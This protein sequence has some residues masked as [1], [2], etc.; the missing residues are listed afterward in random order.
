[1][2]LFDRILSSVARRQP[3]ARSPRDLASPTTEQIAVMSVANII[4]LLLDLSKTENYIP[5]ADIL[6]RLLNI[7]YFDH[8][9]STGEREQAAQVADRLEKSLVGWL[10]E[11]DGE[12]L[13]KATATHKRG[14]KFFGIGSIYWLAEENR[15]PSSEWI[16]FAMRLEHGPKLSAFLEYLGEEGRT[17]DM[18]RLFIHQ[19]IVT[20]RKGMSI[21]AV[22]ILHGLVTSMD[23]ATI[24]LFS[25]NEME[26]FIQAP[27][28]YDRAREILASLSLLPP[29][30][31]AKP[32]VELPRG[33]LQNLGLHIVGGFYKEWAAEDEQKTL[34]LSL[35]DSYRGAVGCVAMA[36]AMNLTIRIVLQTLGPEAAKVV[37]SGVE[38]AFVG[39]SMD[40]EY[41]IG[42]IA[43]T[44]TFLFEKIQQ[45][46]GEGALI[47]SDTLIVFK[48]LEAA[49]EFPNSEQD[50]QAAEELQAKLSFFFGQLRTEVISNIR[51]KLLY[52]GHPTSEPQSQE[53]LAR[54]ASMGAWAPEAERSTLLEDWVGYD[55]LTLADLALISRSVTRHK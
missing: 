36:V 55:I 1:M 50:G 30:G 44:E 46:G 26:A 17:P 45:G 27:D 37:A 31:N 48:M 22:A 41:F 4:K 51:F 54:Y 14:I 8:H 9:V 28:N 19:L 43:E 18:R 47:S 13:I 7:A 5:A 38:E 39:Q 29:H 32:F 42:A 34:L 11:R 35:P 53:T 21:N 15:I 52:L 49:D 10:G 23:S 3:P 33:A 40:W 12:V 16:Q 20:R 24:A 25:P 2:G 6:K